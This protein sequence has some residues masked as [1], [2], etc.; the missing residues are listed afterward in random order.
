MALANARTLFYR[1]FEQQSTPLQQDQTSG[2]WTRFMPGDEGN[3]KDQERIQALTM[4]RDLIVVATDRM[5]LRDWTRSGLQ[6]WIVTIPGASKWLCI[7]GSQLD[8]QIF[9]AYQS[10]SFSIYISIVV[11]FVCFRPRSAGNDAVH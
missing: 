11:I 3:S 9:L 4:T 5:R 10:L 6:P 7:V 1:P 2:E 8:N